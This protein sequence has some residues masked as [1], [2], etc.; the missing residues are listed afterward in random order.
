MCQHHE[1]EV[2]F[3]PDSG[4][5]VKIQKLRVKCLNRERGC[6]WKG[7]VRHLKDHLPECA[8]EWCDVER[9]IHHNMHREGGE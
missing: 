3:F 5:R 7:R 9:L 4:L 6:E 2:E 1:E 8:G